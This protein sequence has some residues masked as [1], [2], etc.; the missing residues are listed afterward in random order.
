MDYMYKRL[1]C[2]PCWT[3]EISELTAQLSRNFKETHRQTSVS[4]NKNKSGANE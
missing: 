3:G 4:S 1:T 2:A